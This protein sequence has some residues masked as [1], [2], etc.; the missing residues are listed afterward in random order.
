MRKKVYC[1]DCLHYSRAFICDY[2]KKVEKEYM[3]GDAVYKP[4]FV[5]HKLY[6]KPY[7]DNKNND[8]LFYNSGAIG[9]YIGLCIFI[10]IFFI[11]NM[12]ANIIG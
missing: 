1:E 8:C 11:F 2:V 7:E 5:K 10:L 12:F 9:V 6:A 4:K 3:D